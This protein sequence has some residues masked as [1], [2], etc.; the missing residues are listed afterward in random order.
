MVDEDSDI[1]VRVSCI[2]KAFGSVKAVDG[3][4]LEVR[5]GTVLAIVGPNGAGKTT[6]VSMLEGLRK[7]DSGEARVLG[8]DPWKDHNFLKIRIGVMPQGFNFFEK[9]TAR[10]SVI[11]YLSLFNSLSDPDEILKM[12]VLDPSSKV[13]FENLSGGQKQK[14]GLALSIVND[15][16]V[17]FLDEPTTGL[18]P[19]ARRAI[20]AVINRF[21]SLGKT[22]ILTT[23][24]ME[25]AEQLADSVAIIDHGKIVAFGTPDEIVSLHGKG[26]RLLI[27]AGK[28]MADFLSAE[29]IAISY[30][31]TNVVVSLGTAHRLSH[32][33]SLIEDSGISYSRLTV[34]AGSLEDVFITLVGESREEA[35]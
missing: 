30:D 6:L 20:W 3:V 1:A 7:A 14:L 25:E 19:S 13:A 12:V 18:D 2:R 31:G 10:D 28:A 26:R 15:P 8:L 33:I 17:L 24:Y 27:R 21:R 23:H 16:E 9:L 34:R 29:G 32:I 5:R 22:I 4:D 11:F 35:E